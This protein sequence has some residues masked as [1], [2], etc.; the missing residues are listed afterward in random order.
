MIL[1][2]NRST[3]RTGHSALFRNINGLRNRLE[4]SSSPLELVFPNRPDEQTALISRL[5]DISACVRQRNRQ[6][7][8]IHAPRV[9][10][11]SDDFPGRAL[12]FARL[13]EMLGAQ[14]VTFHPSKCME[15]EFRL[16]R[17]AAALGNLSQA[18][19]Q[20]DVKLSVET[21]AHKKCLF[22]P[23]EIVRFDLPMVLDT[24]HVGW[25]ASYDL[26]SR[27][28]GRIVTVHLSECVD[29]VQHQRITERSL[30][31]IDYLVEIGW[32]GNVVLEY[33]PWR[34]EYYAGDV[35]VVNKR[36]AAAVGAGLEMQECS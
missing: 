20:T 11:D 24:S 14:S 21:L 7:L 12:E 31:F 27:H 19:D 5:E 3:L 18:Q 23:E 25:H 9:E 8:S 26:I 22:Y 15:P 35:A 4:S 1:H 36:L 16:G 2:N 30:E 28:T 29:G 34:W 10:M 6:V 17:Q 33:W 32:S 13:A